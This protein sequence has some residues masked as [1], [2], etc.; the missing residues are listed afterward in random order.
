MFL[1]NST[2]RTPENVCRSPLLMPPKWLLKDLLKKYPL[3]WLELPSPVLQPCWHDNTTSVPS[4]SWCESRLKALLIVFKIVLTIRSFQ[5]CLD[6]NL[7]SVSPCLNAFF[8]S[9]P[10][11]HCS[12]QADKLQLSFHS[13]STSSTKKK[14]KVMIDCSLKTGKRALNI[15]EAI[16]AL[17]ISEDVSDKERNTSNGK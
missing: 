15:P 2:F 8:E 16:Q 6:F 12:N 1:Q 4:P 11:C 13:L 3:A 14:K 5:S 17:Q 10:G 9:P 7:P